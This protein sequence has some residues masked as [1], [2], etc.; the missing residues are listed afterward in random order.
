MLSGFTKNGQENLFGRPDKT[1]CYRLNS[2][3]NISEVVTPAK[4]G[5]Q[6]VNTHQHWIP[7]FAGMTQTS[8]F[9]GP[10]HKA[11]VRK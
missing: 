4:V 2:V 10:N 11:R 7:A 3:P 9:S 6:D 1:S 5:I 8:G